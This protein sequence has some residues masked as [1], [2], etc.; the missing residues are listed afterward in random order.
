MGP[1]PG[2][3]IAL[4]AGAAVGSVVQ[5][6]FNLLALQQLGVEIALATRLSATAQDLL[7]FA[8]LYAAVFGVSFLASTLIT[9][10]A[11]KLLGWPARSF[12]H[13]LGAAI[14][15]WL[16]FTLVNTFAPMPTLIAATRTSTGLAAMA[17]A[18]AFAGWLYARLTATRTGATGGDAP[19]W[20]LA[21]LALYAAGFCITLFGNV[22]MNRDLATW[23]PTAPPMDP[24]AWLARWTA[25]NH[26]R[27]ALSTAA[28]ATAAMALRRI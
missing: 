2:F 27:M 12:F 23:D 19:V 1:I 9:G 21:A 17:L 7:H 15:L 24:D 26:A 5:T 10:A 25:L 28:L 6:Q 18:A 16:T 4:V 20:L 8:P 14:G 13:A 22:P 3:L 11:L